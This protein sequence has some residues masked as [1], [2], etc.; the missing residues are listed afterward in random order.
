MV[1]C[2]QYTCFSKSLGK[3]KLNL[4]VF[5]V[6]ADKSNNLVES[7]IGSYLEYSYPLIFALTST[8]LAPTVPVNKLTSTSTAWPSSTVTVGTSLCTT[9]IVPFGFNSHMSL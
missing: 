3:S 2:N 1:K 8:S 6:L 5:C 7:L 4:T 9:D